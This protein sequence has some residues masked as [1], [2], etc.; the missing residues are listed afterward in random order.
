MTHLQTALLSLLQGATEFLPISSSGHLQIAR[1]AAERN[2]VDLA[3]LDN[4]GFV[5]L[6][7]VGTLL[8]ICW[9]FRRRLWELAVYGIG[10]AW[11]LVAREGLRRAWIEHPDGRLI[12]AIVIASVPTALAGLLGE[13]F[14]DSLFDDPSKAVWVGW[15]LCFTALLLASTRWLAPPPGKGLDAAAFPLWM[16]L[17]L[18]IAQSVA[19]VPGVSRS[20]ATITIALILGI[21]R[22]TAGELSFLIAVPAI[23]GAM[24][25]KLM[26]SQG[27]DLPVGLCINALAVSAASGYLFLRLLLRFVR[28]GSFWYFAFYCLALGVG[29][30]WYFRNGGA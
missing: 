1:Y 2:G 16:A 10:G 11:R 12:L 17:V 15:A 4:V 24:L 19:L 13:R 9:V 26:G 14:V 25:V 7:H 29:A 5:V 6:V 22:S 3:G 23:L 8:A 18:G 28:S 20:G 27:I 30:I 21:N